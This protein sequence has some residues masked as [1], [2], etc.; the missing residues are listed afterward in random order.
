MAQE[1]V[2]LVLASNDAY[3]AGDIDA[4]VACFALDI[5]AIPD[6]SVFPDAAPL[7]G[8]EEFKRWLEETGSAW[9]GARWITR[10]VRALADSRVML[11][12]DWG[13]QGAA[14]GAETVSSIT[15]VFTVRDGQISR[16]E[17]FFDHAEALKAVGLAE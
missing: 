8:R 2:D 14:S 16:V 13:G 4:T 5:E 1:N 7:H 9:V 12:G 3:N 10:E 6:A 17:Y 15:G 11:R